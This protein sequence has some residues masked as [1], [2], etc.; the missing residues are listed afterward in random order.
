MD[1]IQNYLYTH[2][3]SEDWFKGLTPVLISGFERGR[4]TL[5]DT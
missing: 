3:M 1:I 4:S 5:V 2:Q